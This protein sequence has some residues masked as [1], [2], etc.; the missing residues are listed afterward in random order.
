[1]SRELPYQRKHT[2]QGKICRANRKS[3][4]VFPNTFPESRRLG[5]G[6][7]GVLS[8]SPN[9]MWD[10][11]RRKD[12][13][14][15]ALLGFG[16]MK[17]RCRG[18]DLVPRDFKI[19]NRRRT[20]QGLGARSPTIET[21]HKIA[22]E[23]PCFDQGPGVPKSNS[24]IKD[25]ENGVD[26]NLRGPKWLEAGTGSELYLA[27][28]SSKDFGQGEYTGPHGHASKEINLIDYTALIRGS[29]PIGCWRI[30]QV[31]TWR[32][33]RK[34]S[35]ASGWPIPDTGVR[36]ENPGNEEPNGRMAGPRFPVSVVYVG[37][38]AIEPWNKLEEVW[39]MS[40]S[41]EEERLRRLVLSLTQI[42]NSGGSALDA[43]CGLCR[44][45]VSEKKVQRDSCLEYYKG[46]D[47]GEYRVSMFRSAL[48][49]ECFDVDSLSEKNLDRAACV[50]QT[51]LRECRTVARNKAITHEAHGCT[52]VDQMERVSQIDQQG[53]KQ[54]SFKAKFVMLASRSFQA[55]LGWQPPELR[56]RTGTRFEGHDTVAGLRPR[57]ERQG[58]DEVRSNEPMWSA[59][60]WDD[61]HVGSP[62]GKSKYRHTDI[63]AV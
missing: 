12:P 26:I 44:R 22:R 3:L 20:E 25:P 32:F 14:E 46:E 9:N 63:P 17:A 57:R 27:I 35:Q 2:V 21:L 37:I 60:R 13:G 8:A 30:V 62:F 51:I 43:P 55:V 52:E 11:V 31:K 6:P 19:L 36:K 15:I 53:A 61:G 23:A 40:L 5:K 54:Q 1:M 56:Q 42:R 59:S 29:K 49:I 34:S 39:T 41:S 33:H 7:S 50:A 48:P 4:G 16:S 47:G 28:D 18:I 10:L 38:E 45:T 24:L 58:H